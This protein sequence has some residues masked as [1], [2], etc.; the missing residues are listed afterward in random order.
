MAKSKRTNRDRTENRNPKKTATEVVSSEDHKIIWLFDKLDNDGEF[1]FDLNRIEENNQLK[2]IMSKII[3]YSGF[4]WR[5]AKRQTHDDGKSKNHCLSLEK[6]S[7][8]ARDRVIKLCLEDY[9]DSIFS[10]AF[11][12]KLRVIGIRDN[13]FFHVKW[14]DPEHRFCPSNKKHT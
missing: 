1:A 10:F 5:E 8:E 13:E 2:E 7:P 3:G 11:Q 6:L 9:S 4:T 12:N 14:Y